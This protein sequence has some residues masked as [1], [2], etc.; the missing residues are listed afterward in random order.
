MSAARAAE[1]RA[2]QGTAL[3]PDPVD[4]DIPPRVSPLGSFANHEAKFDPPPGVRRPPARGSS[5]VWPVW[6]GSP[7][8]QLGPGDVRELLPLALRA[9]SRRF[10]RGRRLPHD[11]Q[12]PQP[13]RRMPHAITVI[14]TKS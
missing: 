4:A 14:R 9:G 13:T 8:H 1:G 6:E 2:G 10:T 3:E 5:K 11:F 12:D 7:R